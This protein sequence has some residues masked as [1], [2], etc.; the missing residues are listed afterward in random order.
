LVRDHRNSLWGRA[1][2][3]VVAFT[4]VGSA[5]VITTLFVTAS[6]FT[7][8]LGFGFATVATLRRFADASR[9]EFRPAGDAIFLVAV[10]LV[11]AGLVRAR[12]YALAAA[13]LVPTALA[14]F[15]QG[16]SLAAGTGAAALIIAADVWT[17]PLR[18]G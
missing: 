16:L 3:L 9:I 15:V 14:Q 1:F 6:W 18:R 12:R 11:G 4:L 10:A 7:D 8:R 5:A 13:I 17:R 2:W